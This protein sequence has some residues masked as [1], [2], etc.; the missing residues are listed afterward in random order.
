[1]RNSSR[2]KVRKEFGTTE[3]VGGGAL[4]LVAR[5]LSFKKKKN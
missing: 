1:M 4:K 5:T 3:S 2:Q